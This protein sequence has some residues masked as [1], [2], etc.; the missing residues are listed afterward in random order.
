MILGADFIQAQKLE[1]VH[2][3]SLSIRFLSAPNRLIPLGARST[4]LVCAKVAMTESVTLNPSELSLIRAKVM[5]TGPV[6]CGTT[7]KRL[8]KLGDDP[9]C[10]SSQIY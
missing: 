2:S 3:P 6:E 9:L 7:D 10:S 4:T 5:N 8:H 1:L